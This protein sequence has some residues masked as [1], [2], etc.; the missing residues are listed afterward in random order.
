MRWCKGVFRSLRKRPLE[1]ETAVTVPSL[2]SHDLVFHLHGFQNHQH[3][4]GLDSWPAATFTSRMV[5]GMEQLLAL[6]HLQVAAAAGPEQGQLQERERLQEQG[7]RPL[8]L[9]Q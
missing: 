8:L 5:P 2:G 7:R 3:V 9:L 6:L 1:T 4:A